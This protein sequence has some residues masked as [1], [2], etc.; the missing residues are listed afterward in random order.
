MNTY[1]WEQH[2][3]APRIRLRDCDLCS[4][5]FFVADVEGEYLTAE[6]REEILELPLSEPGDGER[7]R[8]RLTRAGPAGD[9]V[10]TLCAPSYNSTA[11]FDPL[12]H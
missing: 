10:L 1:P 2:P 3:P 11:S 9:N 5:P 6:A 4:Q 12:L 8:I 7:R